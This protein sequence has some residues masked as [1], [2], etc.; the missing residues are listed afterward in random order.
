MNVIE[1][2]N[3]FVDYRDSKFGNFPILAEGFRRAG[4]SAEEI[5]DEFSQ[6]ERKQVYCFTLEDAKGQVLGRFRPHN[7][8][9]NIVFSFSFED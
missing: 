5:I 9:G 3:L 1:R 2:F 6:E 7:Y 8:L 4:Q